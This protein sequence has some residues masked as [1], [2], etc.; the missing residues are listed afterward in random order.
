MFI[1][2]PILAKL[3]HFQVNLTKKKFFFHFIR[4]FFFGFKG[5]PSDQI[6]PLIYSVPSMHICL[7]FIP[8]M[9]ASNELD[10]Q[11]IYLI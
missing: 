9:L 1:T 7:D 8:Q 4:I 11:V 3:V 10:T 6:K 2:N 5:Y